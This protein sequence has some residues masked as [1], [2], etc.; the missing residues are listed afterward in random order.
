MHRVRLLLG[1]DV[2]WD[3]VQSLLAFVENANSSFLD[4]FGAACRLAAAGRPE[5]DVGNEE[6]VQKYE[7]TIMQLDAESRQYYQF[8]NGLLNIAAVLERGKFTFKS[9]AQFHKLDA[10]QG[11]VEALE[12][13]RT[14]S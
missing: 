11:L 4:D 10:A 5:L 9:I 8:L 14:K 1:D 2:V 6:A 7:P 3:R 12:R 13:A